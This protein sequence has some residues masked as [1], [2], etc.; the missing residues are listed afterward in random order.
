[1]K[2]IKK[3][4]SYAKRNQNTEAKPNKVKSGGCEPFSCSL[5]LCIGTLFGF[6]IDDYLE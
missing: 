5:G 2:N 4:K 1:M 3:L 6:W